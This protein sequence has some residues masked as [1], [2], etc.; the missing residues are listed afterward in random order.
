MP[1]KA[2]PGKLVGLTLLESAL[3][4]VRRDVEA[5]KSPVG[6]GIEI[7]FD[8]TKQAPTKASA[9][10]SHGRHFPTSKKEGTVVG[11]IFYQF[12]SH[13]EYSNTWA[14]STLMIE[15]RLLS[16]SQPSFLLELV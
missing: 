8:S 5:Q 12:I 13:R 4:G 11:M 6:R 16:N 14:T 3:K 15:L 10:R 1:D 9:G 2:F 7:F